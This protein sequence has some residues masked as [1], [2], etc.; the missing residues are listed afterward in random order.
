[1]TSSLR[2]QVRRVSSSFW[3]LRGKLTSRRPHTAMYNDGPAR[4]AS[5]S[6]FAKPTSSMKRSA[7]TALST[8]RSS[9]RRHIRSRWSSICSG[10]GGVVIR[11]KAAGSAKG[12][13]W[14][15]S[16]LENCRI[17]GLTPVLRSQ[18]LPRLR[19]DARKK[20]IHSI[21]AG[22]HYLS[23]FLFDHLIVKIEH[24]FL[25]QAIRKR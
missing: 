2:Y 5:V 17:V 13:F 12:N 25:C 24:C 15:D 18:A 3:T 6:V 16:A 22:L 7:S 20:T 1:M 19:L 4:R 21:L 23:E 14:L 11:L 10:R 9:S 8:R